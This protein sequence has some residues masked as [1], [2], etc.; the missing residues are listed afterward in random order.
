MLRAASVSLL[1][2]A[3][4]SGACTLC[5]SSL[6]EQVRAGVAD[7]GLSMS[8]AVV[9]PGAALAGIIALAVRWAR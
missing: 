9:A 2:I 8:L 5:H 3:A 4:P 7:G 1:L 6:A